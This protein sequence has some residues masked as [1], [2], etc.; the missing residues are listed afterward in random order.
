EEIKTSKCSIL[1]YYLLYEY[2][3]SIINNKKLSINELIQPFFNS[4]YEFG[5]DDRLITHMIRLSIKSKETLSK[6][7]LNKTK[8]FDIYQDSNSSLIIESYSIILLI[9]QRTNLLLE[10]HENHPT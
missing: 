6:Y 8:P 4:L 7:I 10:T 1:P 3:S 5:E 9:E 2:F